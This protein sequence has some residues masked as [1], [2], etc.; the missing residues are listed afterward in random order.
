MSKSSH[1]WLASSLLM[2]V[3]LI[4]AAVM[5]PRSFALTAFSDIIQSLLLISGTAAFIPLAMRARGRIRFFWILITLGVAFWLSY[6]L[7]WTYYEVVLRREVPDLCT[8]DIILF[9]HIVPFMGALAMRPHVP[10]DEYAARIG[11]LDFALLLVWWFYLYVL[12]VMP[13]QYVVPDVATYNKNLNIVYAAE[14]IALLTSLV[15][16]WILSK[17]PWQKLYGALFGMSLCYSASSTLANWA[18]GRDVY[19]SGSLYDVPLVIAMGWLTWIGRTTGDMQP[20]SVSPRV[21]TVY[22]VWIARFGMIAVFSLPIFAA[23][24]MA[25][26][27]IPSRVR[28][29]RLTLTLVAAFLMGMMVFLRQRMLDKEL[30]RLLG[31]SRN[32]FDSLKRLQA[33]IL[34][35]EK[36]ASIAQLV[37]GAAHE[38]NNPITAMLGYSDLLLNTALTAEQQP[39]AAKIGQYVRRTRSLVASLISFA[40]Q[41]PAPKAPVDL[42]TLARTSLKLA[43][44]QWEAMQIEIRSQFEAGLPKVHGDSNQLLQVC[45]QLLANSMHVLSER[46]GKVLIVSSELQAGNCVLQLVTEATSSSDFSDVDIRTNPED[47]LAL[48]ACQGIL[49][50][51]RGTI[52]SRHQEDG[53]VLLRMELPAIDAAPAKPK[54]TTVPVLWQSRPFA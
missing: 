44:P 34:Q 24:S 8:W 12:I 43:Q 5:L 26:D 16:C 39:F 48:S 23:W 11:H 13:W 22:G 6:Q 28:I 19:Y 2:L 37:G 47:G 36:L 27:Q 41:S 54:D 20:D 52:T 42:N 49:Q 33:Q 31:Q 53:A 45:L 40:R 50:E 35:S 29:F 3:A 7:Y 4:V 46:G 30:I 1:L 18:I 10:R 15:V 9:L 14:K 17:G 32:S 25:D 51:H 38:L 21:S